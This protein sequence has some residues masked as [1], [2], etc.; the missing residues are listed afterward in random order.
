[1]LDFLGICLSL[2]F[3][4][5]V[6]FNLLGIS[7]PGSVT[8]LPA[9]LWMLAGVGLTAI[10][11]F[12]LHRLYDEEVYSRRLNQ[13]PKIGRALLIL[14]AILFVFSFFLKSD[15]FFE[16]RS[17]PLLSFSFAF[18]SVSFLRLILFREIHRRML[19]RGVGVSRVAIVG[20][21]EKAE[22]L[23][24]KI[25]D[26]DRTRYKLVAILTQP[27][28]LP[29]LLR[30]NRVD[31]VF[32]TSFPPKE[33]IDIA[34]E[35]R[36]MRVGVNVVSDVFGV[37]TG[38]VDTELIDGLPLI[39]L[40]GVP[41]GSFPKV[42]KRFADLTITLLLLPLLSPLL[43]LIAI[44]VK[45]TSRGPILFTQK[46]IG[47][48]GR[49][50]NFYKFRSMYENAESRTHRTWIRSFIYNSDSKPKG[51]Q[52]ITRDHRVTW[53]GYFLRRSSLD[54]LPQLMNVLRGE[55]SLIGPRPP[56]PYEAELYKVWHKKRLKMKPGITGLWQVSGRSSVSF[57]QMVL[58]DI[59]YAENWSLSLD[60]EI[61][62]KTIPVVISRRGA[63]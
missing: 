7:K 23:A 26:F 59:Y 57:N 45:L 52:K 20:E 9:H 18:V 47:E 42:A 4:F 53:F 19:D 15:L 5:S 1:M 8:L 60:L 37:F 51:V 55:M 54:E 32:L 6:R 16:R 39:R 46:R 40:N 41:N 63:Y 43:G 27:V 25:L 17:I 35:C 34:S 2:L 61:L 31:E 10:L 58:L 49:E 56:I 22:E 38:K 33:T 11:V 62:L 13:L 44:G 29:D 48:G 36:D 14:F 12:G 3:A 30:T 21:R 50:F 28:H 24:R